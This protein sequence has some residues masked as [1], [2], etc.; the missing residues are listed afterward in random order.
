MQN[1]PWVKITYTTSGSESTAKEKAARKRLE[2]GL[3]QLMAQLHEESMAGV[4][5]IEVYPCPK[6]FG[7][8]KVA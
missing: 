4:L 2:T 6:D 5:E 1:E 3:N 7:H 8:C